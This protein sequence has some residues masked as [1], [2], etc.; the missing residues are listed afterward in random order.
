MRIAVGSDHRGYQLKGRLDQ[1][2]AGLGHD[3]VDVGTCDGERVDYT[4]FAE[5]VAR[6]VASGEADRGILICG[7]GIGMA[8]TANKFPGVRA[9]TAHDELTAEMC[10]R[11]NDVNVLCLSGDMLAERPIDNMINVWLQTEFEGGR[12]ARR[13]EKIRQLEDEITKSRC[14]Q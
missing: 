14:D 7:T 1:M 8:I 3:V 4:D 12:H 10:R 13:V 5:A 9:A 2:L 6:K 11:H